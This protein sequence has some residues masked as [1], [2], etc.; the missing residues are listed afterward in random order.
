MPLPPHPGPSPLAPAL[1]THQLRGLPWGSMPR[2]RCRPPAWR[3]SLPGSGA[4]R[5]T[6]SRR[7]G[8]TKSPPRGLKRL[9]APGSEPNSGG[10]GPPLPP[11][12]QDTKPARRSQTWPP[13]RT[14]EPLLPLGFLGRG[15]RPAPCPPASRGATC[16]HRP[17]PAQCAA[18]LPP[19]PPDTEG[20]RGTLETSSHGSD[21]PRVPPAPASCSEGRVST[22]CLTRL[23]VGVNSGAL[24]RCA[25]R[26][27]R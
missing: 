11:Q 1:D 5:T 14:A 22:G 12:T 13:S 2:G 20:A 26:A 3:G 15:S 7:G 9:R 21:P 6:G 25:Q 17:R 27:P 24:S 18:R 10:D 23:S 4:P 8:A 19:R 16:R